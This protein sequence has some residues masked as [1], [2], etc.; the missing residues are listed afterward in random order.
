MVLVLVL[1]TDH[2][3]EF[4][5]ASAAGTRLKRRLLASGE[6]VAAT[7]ISVEEQ[8]RGWVSTCFRCKRV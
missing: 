3:V 8:F 2:L 1:D 4:D 6:E 7:I 5:E